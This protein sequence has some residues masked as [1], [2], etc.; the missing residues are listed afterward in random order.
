M[1]VADFVKLTLDWL[2]Y[3]RSHTWR[4]IFEQTFAAAGH[5][6]PKSAIEC[7]SVACVLALV[8]ASDYVTLVPSQLFAERRRNLRSPRWSWTP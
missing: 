7:T 3:R 5:E 8:E 4:D 6:P 1:T 2:I